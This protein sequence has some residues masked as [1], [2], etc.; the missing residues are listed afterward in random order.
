ML[1]PVGYTPYRGSSAHTA[2]NA[3]RATASC[4]LRR[5]PPSTDVCVPTSP[6]ILALAPATSATGSASAPHPIRCTEP[7]S[8]SCRD[9]QL[10]LRCHRAGPELSQLHTQRSGLSLHPVW[11]STSNITRLWG[12]L[13]GRFRGPSEAGSAPLNLPALRTH[14]STRLTLHSLLSCGVPRYT[15]APPARTPASRT[16]PVSRPPCPLIQSPPGRSPPGDSLV[17]GRRHR[18]PSPS[19]RAPVPVDDLPAPST[20][21][22]PRWCCRFCMFDLGRR[23]AERAVAVRLMRLSRCLSRMSL[24]AAA[25]LCSLKV[26]PA[27]LVAVLRPA[28]CFTGRLTTGHS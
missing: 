1:A 10:P 19:R 17:S 5:R 6:V 21:I 11:P 22:R 16:H 18:R 2:T 28:V 14:L 12:Y 9:H 15:Q 27:S 4:Q 3:R 25:I 26:P 8:H 23:S 24:S 7:G 13:R 20:L